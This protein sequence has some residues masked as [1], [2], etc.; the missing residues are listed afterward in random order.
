VSWEEESQQRMNKRWMFSRDGKS[1]T[2][3]G[4]SY[5]SDHNCGGFK[6]L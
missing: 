6:A 3:W 4:A 2:D 5:G 1:A